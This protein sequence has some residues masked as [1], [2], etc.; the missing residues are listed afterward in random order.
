M[1]LISFT[2][3]FNPDTVEKEIKYNLE[4]EKNIKE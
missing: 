4:T 3:S 2:I 1:L